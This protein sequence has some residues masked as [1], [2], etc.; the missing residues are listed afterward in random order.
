M[1]EMKPLAMFHKHSV[2]QIRR[3][4]KM[5]QLYHVRTEVNAADI[6]GMIEPTI[7]GRAKPS[8]NVSNLDLLELS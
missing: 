4:S 6:A 8:Q 5:E 7:F 2:L 1:A 3:G